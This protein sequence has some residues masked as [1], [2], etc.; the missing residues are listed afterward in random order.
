[1]ILII[2]LY[3][4]NQLSK[5]IKYLK[6]FFYFLFFFLNVTSVFSNE[7]IIIVGNKNIPISTIYSFVPNDL[8]NLI[9][10]KINDFQKK[11]FATGF[12]NTV[13]LEV[14]EN[15]LYVYLDENPLINFFFIDGLKNKKELN[16]KLLDITKLKEN[17][18]FQPYQVKEDIKNLT[19]YLNQLG[20]LNNKI[21][22]Q[23]IKI[24]NNKINVFY[25]IQLNEKFKIN[26]IFF[27]GEK[28][29]KSSTLKDAVYSSEYGWWK[30]LSSSTTPSES[31]INFDISKLKNF[32]QEN[33]FYD[34]QI[35][36]YS[37]K[38]IDNKFANITYSINAGNKYFVNDI[39]LI[40]ESKS[41]S[42]ENIIFLENIY[43]KNKKKIYNKL[44]V[45]KIYDFTNDYLVKSNFDLNVDASVKK[46]NMSNI[47]L[48]YFIREPANK[49]IINKIIISGNDLTDDF[50]IRNNLSFSEG[51]FYNQNKIDKSI[52][53]IKGTNLFKDTSFN[54]E[55]SEQN[56]NEIDLTIKVV[57]QPT[58]EIL[59]AVGA[60]TDGATISGG[61]NEKNFLG[62]G[63]NLNSNISLGTQKIYGSL[64]Y[65]NPDFKNSGNT[66]STKFFI[67]NN[68]LDNASYE[69]K[70]IGSSISFN[71]EFYDKFFLT[72]GIAFDY[73][74]LSANPDASSL[75]KNREGD[76]F[77]SKIF[78]NVYKNTKNRE[79][80]TTD[81]FTIGFGQGFSILSD[82][83]YISN[84]FFGSFYDEYRDNFVA[85]I[86][87]KIE[88]I[89]G[90]GEDIKYSDRLS[91]S[92]SN[93]RGFSSRGI[94]PKLEN[95]F[96]GGNYLYYGTFSS[97]IPNGLPD[98]WSAITNVFFDTANVWGVDDNSTNDSNKF[99]SSI[100]V[101]LSW[102]SPLGPI[103]MTYAEP[104]TKEKTDEVEQFSFKIGSAF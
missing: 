55:S 52:D 68:D 101:G 47:D 32:Y 48:F 34:V 16:N 54:I 91:V 56:K 73:D 84:S 5:K 12:F 82:I 46:T 95:D 59:A 29:F 69:N 83:P 90:F 71:Y 13:K 64:I 9:P 65:S 98:K 94:G 58:G 80:Q 40:D 23:L 51:D 100:G 25:N 20:Y 85:S 102:I 50:V 96:I 81:G 41:L 37:I 62:R 18:I 60:G 4:L 24:E 31:Q 39:K 92:S 72:P 35:N 103:S 36:S 86:K 76:F 67:E 43:K 7:K 17:T 63:V 87:Y 15:K 27:T 19:K 75:V 3:L 77:T 97:T 104:I 49:N 6:L 10:D 57:E 79:F 11:L 89:N 61:L 42:K 21:N 8:D 1:M 14:K 66:L 28:F 33:G 93:L 26:R 70:I 2:Q 88:S 78:Y 45:K 44:E 99:R 38:L 53:K 22:S 30:F 74:S